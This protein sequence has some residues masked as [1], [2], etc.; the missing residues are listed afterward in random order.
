MDRFLTK[1]GFYTAGFLTTIVGF[2]A[3]VLL[4]LIF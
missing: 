4:A 3:L 2:G 1:L